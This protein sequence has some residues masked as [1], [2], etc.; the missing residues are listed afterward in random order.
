MLAA[1]GVSLGGTFP[2]PQIYGGGDYSSAKIYDVIDGGV[3]AELLG[4]NK[5]RAEAGKM[6]HG[7]VLEIAVGSGLQI[8]WYEWSHLRSYTGIDASADMLVGARTRLP[9]SQTKSRLEQANA[10]D[11]SEFANN[12]FDTVVDTFSFCVFDDP[13]KAMAEMKR[14]VKS[15]GKIILLE[16]SVSTNTLLRWL[17]QKMSPIVTPFSRGCRW[18]VDV[19]AIA[20]SAE[21]R[22][23]DGSSHDSQLG[24][25]HLGVYSK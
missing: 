19:P 7:D 3:A 1:A 16:N 2:F 6:A 4:L 14:V 12:S 20:Q 15:S 22:L 17:Q 10:S 5:L 8:P 21:I 24:T 23:D 11:L 9:I 25:I 18:D 13:Y